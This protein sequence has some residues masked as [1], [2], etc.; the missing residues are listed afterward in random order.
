[1]AL[2]AHRA[3]LGAELSP[4]PIDGGR[5]SA[6]GSTAA[7]AADGASAKAYLGAA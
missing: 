4:A 7:L 1:M 2:P 3:A 5:I 6:Q